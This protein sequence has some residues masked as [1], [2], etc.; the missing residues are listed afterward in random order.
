MR[1]ENFSHGKGK[2]QVLVII[3][4]IFLFLNFVTA[5]YEDCGVYGN[6]I[7]NITS[8]TTYINN[9]N[10]SEYWMDMGSIN[11]TQLENSG[12]VLSI[13][14]SW[15][16]SLISGTASWN[17]SGTDVFLNHIGD[18]V[19]IGTTTPTHKLNVIGDINFTGSLIGK[20]GDLV[21][22]VN[23][24]GA[25]AIRIKAT[26]DNV[27]VVIGGMTG[28]FSVW[29]VAD[30]TAVFYV[31]E[32]GA[33]DITGILDMNTNKIVGVVNPT[34]NQDVAT[35]KYVDDND[36]WNMSGGFLYPRYS[37]NV[38]IGTT[39]PLTNLHIRGSSA[40]LEAADFTSDKVIIEDIDAVL[41]LYSTEGGSAGSEII[42]G[43]IDTSTFINSWSFVRTTGATPKLFFS[44]GTNV[45]PYLNSPKLTLQSDGNVGIGTI[46]PTHKLN[47]VGDGNFTGSI[48]SSN[49]FIP[50]YEFS[51]TNRTHA[52]AF[53]NVWANL[54]FDQEDSDVAFGISHTYNDNTNSTFTFMEPGVYEIDYDYDVEDT[55][56]SA[57]DIDVA[58]RLIYANGTE[59]IGSEFETD[60]TKQ[61][62][63]TELSHDFLAIFQ[64]GDIVVFQFVANDVD[65]VISTHGI[66]G[67]HP[68]SA[69][70][71]IKKIA[72]I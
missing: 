59:I 72:N 37:G 8:S 2:L 13:I 66:F 7:S 53:V 69:S 64:V 33:T 57:S 43:E 5:S 41:G 32:R 18:S 56:P 36:F 25:D 14:Q 34:A 70:I 65:V 17:R 28:L 19:G 49:V 61:G 35:K 1:N 4:S 39:S 15:I 51:H 63:S 26:G 42:L 30:N 52:L 50:Q 40:A 9:T 10:N 48:I 6:C 23:P 55:S 58:G 29:N 46:N 44:F 22:E 54:T 12:G 21:S 31:T 68:E 16:E 24:D 27:D 67:D 11:A 62:A 60:I 3:F 38:G 47:V 20:F 45:N 71:V